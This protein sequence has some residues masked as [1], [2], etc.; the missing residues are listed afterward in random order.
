MEVKVNEQLN[1]K[2]P[3]GKRPSGKRLIVKRPNG[4]SPTAPA[5]HTNNQSHTLLCVTQSHL[6]SS[7]CDAVRA[8]YSDY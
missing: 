5:L 4:K 3:N 6:F 2:R 8:Q 1:G 7:E